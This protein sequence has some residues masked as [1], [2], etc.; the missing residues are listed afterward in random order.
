MPALHRVQTVS[1]RLTV[2]VGRLRLTIVLSLVLRTVLVL[3]IV[4]FCILVTGVW[5]GI[6]NIWTVLVAA[7]LIYCVM[8]FNR[9]GSRQ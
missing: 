7:L 5:R 3:S 8:G 4:S 9:I 2:C 6:R 1:V